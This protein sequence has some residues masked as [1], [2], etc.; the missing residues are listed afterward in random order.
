[1][2][3][4]RYSLRRLLAAVAALAIVCAFLA[5]AADLQARALSGMTLA[6]L[7]VST[8]S[9]FALGGGLRAFAIGFSAV[10]WAYYAASQARPEALPTVRWIEAAFERVVG[11]PTA[12][13]PE[14]AA[15][16]VRQLVSFLV[17]GHLVL[18]I[19]AAS[20]A[21]LIALAAHAL[22]SRSPRTSP[23]RS[24]S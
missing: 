10:G 22:A 16:F 4:P 20:V 3:G 23:G 13:G 11:L 18:T 17:V 1:M 7:A 6:I 14:E 5:L 21:G 12:L 2:P 9:G 15:A 24:M 8:A 19:L